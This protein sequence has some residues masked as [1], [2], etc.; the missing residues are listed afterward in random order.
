MLGA[1]EEGGEA[2]WEARTALMFDSAG[3]DDELCAWSE[4]ATFLEDSVGMI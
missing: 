3:S 4:D 2:A 1:E